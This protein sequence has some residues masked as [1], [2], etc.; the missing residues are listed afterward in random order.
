MLSTCIKVVY[1]HELNITVVRTDEPSICGGLF[2][3]AGRS[4]CAAGFPMCD[5]LL[6][7]S[8][9]TYPTATLVY[10]LRSKGLRYD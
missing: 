2:S 8:D 3:V 10:F 6:V 9:Y 5:F 4:S 1:I 7:F